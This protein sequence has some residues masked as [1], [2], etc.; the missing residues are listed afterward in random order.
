[1]GGKASIVLV[2]GFSIIFS[3][4]Q[5]NLSAMTVDAAENY[6]VNYV[7]V[8][9]HESAVSAMNFAV[10]KVWNTGVIYDSFTVIAQ[11]C[12]AYVQIDTMGKDT[13]RVRSKAWSRVFEKDAWAETHQP[14]LVQDS[15]FALFIGRIPGNQYMWFSN[16]ETGIN[17]ITGDTIFGPVHTNG[18][19]RTVGSPVFYGKVTAGKGIS[20]VPKTRGS[21]AQ[22]LGG[23]EI[24][25][26]ATMETN[27][28]DLVNN[29]I[30][31]NGWSPVNTKCVYN[32]PYQFEFLPNGNVIRTDKSIPWFPV[33]KDTVP[34]ATIAPTG[35]IYSTTDIYIKGTLN[36]A[37][38]MYTLDDIWIEDDIVY[39]VNPVVD[40]TSDDML[41][42]IANDDI[43]ITD[44]AV[45]NR[46]C[47]VHACLLSLYGTFG[48]QN[49]LI[50]PD[51][52]TLTVV[53]SIG[54]DQE[55]QVGSWSVSVFH[56]YHKMYYFDDRFFH[57]YPPE[58]PYVKAWTLIAWWE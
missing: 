7:D 37:V 40:P 32:T 21:R 23:W 15:L 11:S 16:Q 12:T 36:G 25:I 46:D 55:G 38:T 20:P 39:A 47:T 43:I 33:V 1:M 29:A 53:G 14:K 44:N 30:A 57:M 42:L 41:G 49:A 5:I 3:Y 52:G 18:V 58:F 10:N 27:M 13:I 22:Y 17:W 48:A 2:I 54:Q 56:G 45:N 24:G 8:L 34:L 6:N 4:Y 50:R 26:T 19:I 35:V 9:V 28:T 51:A 31:A